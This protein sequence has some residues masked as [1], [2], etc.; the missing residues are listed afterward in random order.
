M[1]KTALQIISLALIVAFSTTCR[2][3]TPKPRASF[4]PPPRKGFVNDY[5]NLLD[6]PSAEK[7]DTTLAHLRDTS[8]IEFAVLIV[9]SIGE[10][11]LEDYSSAVFRSWHFDPSNDNDAKILLLVAAKD[12]LYRF[13]VTKALW[14][15]LPDAKLNEAGSLM[16]DAFAQEKYGEGLSNCIDTIIA[17]L[18]NRHRAEQFVGPERGSTPL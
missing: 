14:D 18:R 11:S 4:P 9:D 13:N 10:H 17:T 16:T 15:D 1:T 5:S 8:K 12:S 3:Q 7:I 6:K 2:S